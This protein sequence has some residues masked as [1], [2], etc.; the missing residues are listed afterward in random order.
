MQQFLRLDQIYDWMGDFQRKFW[1]KF[2]LTF[3]T[4]DPHLCF[5]WLTDTCSSYFGDVPDWIDDRDI[6]I[7]HHEEN[8]VGRRKKQI[9]QRSSRK[10]K[11]TDE[12]IIGA[13][14]WHTSTVHIHITTTTEI[15]T[16]TTITK[17][18]RKTRFLNDMRVPSTSTTAVSS[19]KNDAP[20][21]MIHWFTIRMFIVWTQL[22]TSTDNQRQWEQPVFR[23]S[24]T[25]TF[26][27]FFR[28]F[29]SVIPYFY[30]VSR[31]K[32]YGIFDI[33]LTNLNLCS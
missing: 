3:A 14:M 25:Y 17:T 19:V 26:R 18:T 20:M 10:P 6:T 32:V 33:S 28:G 24:H 4:A 11:T 22:H 31:K 15:T 1:C 13:V 16:I 29:Y 8:S 23:V 5:D 9:P 12:L 30:T 7:Q 2:R 21:S 27:T